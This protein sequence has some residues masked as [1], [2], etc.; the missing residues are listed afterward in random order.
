MNHNLI[1]FMACWPL[2]QFFSVPK[3]TALI[4]TVSLF[5]VQFKYN[6][7]AKNGDGKLPSP[8]IVIG[9]TTW[10]QYRNLMN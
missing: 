10:V 2:S 9:D 8:F 3:T 6:E 7:N 4:S 1:P 5:N